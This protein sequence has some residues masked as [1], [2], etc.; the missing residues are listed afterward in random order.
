MQAILTLLLLLPATVPGNGERSRSTSPDE[1]LHL[2]LSVTTSQHEYRMKDDVRLETQ[3]TNTGNR[4]LYLFDEPCW[5]LLNV[6][7]FTT[8][9]EKVTGKPDFIR[10]CLPPPPRPNDRSRFTRLGPGD[11]HRVTQKFGIT[12]LVPKPG[13]YDIVLLYRSDLSDEWVHKY[14]GKKMTALPIWTSE[15]P[16]LKSNRLHLVVK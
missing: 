6:Q 15:Q 16:V 3:L 10:E 13:E 11:V 4:V 12:E 2:A 8:D 14:G 1:T 5:N 7:V 9:G